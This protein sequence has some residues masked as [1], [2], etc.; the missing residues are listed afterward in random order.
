[1]TRRPA[2]PDGLRR[3]TACGVERRAYPRRDGIPRVLRSPYDAGFGVVAKGAA[4]SIGCAPAPGWRCF[5]GRR[6]T[7]HGC[8]R[9]LQRGHS[10]RRS[11]EG[12]SMPEAGIRQQWEGAAPGWARWEATS[13]A[14]YSSVHRQRRRQ[15]ASGRFRYCSPDMARRVCRGRADTESGAALALCDEPGGALDWM[16]SPTRGVRR[17]VRPRCS[18]GDRVRRPATHGSDGMRTSVRGGLLVRADALS[19][20]SAAG[21]GSGAPAQRREATGRGR[22]GPSPFPAGRP[23]ERLSCPEPPATARRRRAW[24]LGPHPWQPRLVRRV[25]GSIHD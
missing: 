7:P 13:P 3:P 20:V 9:A 4:P 1:M 10:G 16:R 5:D 17:S 25:V 15:H 6:R 12:R 23:T 2:P 8:R 19:V 24:R 21:G 22:C 14:M 18:E 11:N